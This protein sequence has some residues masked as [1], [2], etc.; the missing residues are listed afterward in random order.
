[1]A[2]AQQ[3]MLMDFKKCLMELRIVGT[4]NDPYKKCAGYLFQL[5]ICETT[6]IA[7]WYE[8]KNAGNH[9]KI[10]KKIR[11]PLKFEYLSSNVSYLMTVIT[12]SL[13]WK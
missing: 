2:D 13:S 9:G 8:G 3:Y 4:I 5:K 12:N 1:M 11:F 7:E 6:V 10:L